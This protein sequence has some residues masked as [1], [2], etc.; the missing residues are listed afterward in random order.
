MKIPI[1]AQ[2]KTSMKA[3]MN[4]PDII[5]M[6]LKKAAAILENEGIAISNITMTVSP[7][8]R[9]NECRDN[10]NKDYFRVL[11]VES[12]G[13]NKVAILACNPFCNMNS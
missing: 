13:E 11:R 4:V 2:M 3:S 5:G 9:D 1:K 6:D 12:A 7:Y 10:S 8:C